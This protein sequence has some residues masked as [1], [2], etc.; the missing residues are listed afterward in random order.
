[1]HSTYNVRFTELSIR[2]AKRVLDA[3]APQSAQKNIN[4]QD[5]RPLLLAVPE[6]AEQDAVALRYEAFQS[7][8][9]SEE[10]ALGKYQCEKIALMD[11][12]LTGRVRVTPLLTS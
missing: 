8:L 2:K 4:L 7:Q 6:K 5:L 10:E 11:D 12:L 1:V 3:R 9:H